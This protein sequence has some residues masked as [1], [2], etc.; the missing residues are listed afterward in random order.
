MSHNA[1]RSLVYATKTSVGEQPTTYIT[2]KTVVIPVTSVAEK[3]KT[4]TSSYP[5]TSTGYNTKVGAYFKE[6]LYIV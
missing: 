4:V 6:A 3:P 2:T 5:F 1:D